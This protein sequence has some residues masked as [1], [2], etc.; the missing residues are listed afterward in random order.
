L[1]DI[2]RSYKLRDDDYGITIRQGF[3][4]CGAYRQVV[5]AERLEE[6]PALETELQ[7]DALRGEEFYSGLALPPGRDWREERDRHLSE[8]RCRIEWRR[9]RVS[10]PKCLECGSSSI[11]L[12]PVT[13]DDDDENGESP[14]IEHPDCGGCLRVVAVGLARSRDWVFYTP[15]GD[16]IATYEAFPS[17]GLVQRKDSFYEPPD[18]KPRD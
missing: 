8:L 6:L 12:I 7:Q 5:Y 15:E 10:P 3:A 1:H 18:V 16:K 9:S 2:L 11:L 13:D 14:E 17:K 4:W